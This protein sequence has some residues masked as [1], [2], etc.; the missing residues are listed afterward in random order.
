MKVTKRE[1][2]SS[3]IWING[4]KIVDKDTEL[5]GEIDDTTIYLFTKSGDKEIKMK[6][7][8]NIIQDENTKKESGSN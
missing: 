6:F 1:D 3:E 8:K 2:I 5:Y 4:E 7:T